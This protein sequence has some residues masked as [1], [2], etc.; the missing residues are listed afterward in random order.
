[1]KLPNVLEL[2][3]EPISSFR[4]TPDGIEHLRRCCI[5]HGPALLSFYGRLDPT[6]EVAVCD[7]GTLAF[8]WR[9]DGWPLVARVDAEDWSRIGRDPVHTL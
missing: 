3:P 7:D 6:P 4:L 9:M 1:M 8:F 5:L 2:T